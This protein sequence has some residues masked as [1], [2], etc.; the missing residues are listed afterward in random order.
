MADGCP[1]ELPLPDGDP[2]D[3]ADLDVRTRQV[4]QEKVRAALLPQIDT[5]LTQ[6]Y[7]A[8]WEQARPPPERGHGVHAA[9][10]RLSGYCS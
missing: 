10:S 2:G 5:A 8:A 3:E 1:H 4:W 9:L 6:E 7:G